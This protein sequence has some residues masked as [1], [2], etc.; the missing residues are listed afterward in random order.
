MYNY[1][2]QYTFISVTGASSTFTDVPLDNNSEDL[3]KDHGNE[4]SD[5]DSVDEESLKDT[6]V[7]LTDDQKAER[8]VIAEELKVAGNLAFKDGQF[9]RSIEKYTEGA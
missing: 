8:Q 4:E 7:D 6:E 2:Y 1:L 3:D 5:S 9:E